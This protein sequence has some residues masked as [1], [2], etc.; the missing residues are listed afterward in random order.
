MAYDINTKHKDVEK[1]QPKHVPDAMCI[2]ITSLNNSFFVLLFV[3]LS[4]NWCKQI[5]LR[6]KNLTFF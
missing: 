2:N 5:D 4:Y 1:V 3:F 6:K